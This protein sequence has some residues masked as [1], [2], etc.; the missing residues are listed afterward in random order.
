MLAAGQAGVALDVYA[1]ALVVGKVQLQHIVL[2]LGHLVDEELDILHRKEVAGGVEHE[3]TTGKAGG[4]VDDD[5]RH[6]IACRSA[7]I[8]Q[9]EL[10]ERG[11]GAVE[12]LGR[13]AA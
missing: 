7:H 1:P 11:R 5:G 8:A 6:L 3:G 12:G 2:V 13:A 10:V 4:I 9:Q